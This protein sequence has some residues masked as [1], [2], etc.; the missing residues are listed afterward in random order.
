MEKAEFFIRKERKFRLAPSA[1]MEVEKAVAKVFK[2]TAVE[3]SMETLYFDTEEHGFYNSCV[4]H[5]RESVKIR[6]RRYTTTGDQFLELKKRKGLETRK[7]RVAVGIEKLAGLMSGVETDLSDIVEPIR[8]VFREYRLLPVGA[9]SCVRLSY[10]SGDPLVRVTIDS[11]IIYHRPP[12]VWELTEKGNLLGEVLLKED[13]VVLEAKSSDG[14]SMLLR[15]VLSGLER[16]EYS[17]FL[18]AVGVT[19][20]GKTGSI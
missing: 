5:P 2:V 4:K 20:D 12:S 14:V 16:I 19:L 10:E 3:S 11:E 8:V 7:W 15:R 1:L 17:K 6:F 18:R 13:F 9:V